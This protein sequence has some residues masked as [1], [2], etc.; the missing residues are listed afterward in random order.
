VSTIASVIRAEV[1]FTWG[2][3]DPDPPEVRTMREL[4]AEGKP[5]PHAGREWRV[6]SYIVNRGEVNSATFDLVRAADVAPA[7]EEEGVVS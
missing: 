6:T 3:Q 1:S 4:H 7:P 2:S 5:V